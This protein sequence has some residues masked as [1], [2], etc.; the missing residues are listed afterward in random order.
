MLSTDQRASKFV[1]HE[2]PQYAPPKMRILCATDLSSRSEAAVTRALRLAHAL[3]A[4]CMLLHVVSDDVA[5][6]LAGRRAER[7]H[8][9]LHWQARHLASLRVEPKVSVRVGDPY[10]TIARA[11]SE[12]GAHLIVMG[13]QRKRSL[14]SARRTSAEWVSHRVGRPVLI[15]NSTAEREYSSV[16]FAGARTIGPY[17]Q[18]VDQLGMLDTAHVSVVPQLKVMDRVILSVSRALAIT[19]SSFVEAIRRRIHGSTQRWIEEAGLHLLGF[20][21]VSRPNTP[22]ALLARLTKKTTPQLLVVPARRF[23]IFGRD[24]ASSS[25]AIAL[26]T[27]ACDVLIACEKSAR[28]ALLSPDLQ[29]PL[30]PKDEPVK[31]VAIA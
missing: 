29:S 11:A 17:V 21:I 7:A 12:W 5:L 8:N 31:D 1:L 28:S 27:A 26:R 2:A 24:L 15:V 18:L 30:Q 16:T 25:A 4:D 13:R 14:Q 19:K 3:K 23:G 22:R 10:R 9:A 6:R 20:E